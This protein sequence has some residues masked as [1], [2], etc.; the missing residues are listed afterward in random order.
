MKRIKI[1]AGGWVGLDLIGE[2]WISVK[3]RKMIN[4]F[5]VYYNVYAI[6]QFS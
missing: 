6:F 1:G 2:G 5:C 4:P 3:L